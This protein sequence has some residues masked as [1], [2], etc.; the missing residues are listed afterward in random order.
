[1][2]EVLADP[3]AHEVAK[4]AACPN[5]RHIGALP[6]LSLPAAP[7]MV[8]SAF[9]D[10][11]DAL[12]VP[13]GD[14]DLAAC[15]SCGFLFSTSFDQAL[16][17]AGAKYE[18]SQAA[19]PHFGAFARALATDWVQRYGLEGKPIAE[20]GCG[21]GEFLIEMIRAGAGSAVGIDPLFGP[22]FI[23]A[24]FQDRI[25]ADPRDFG[26]DHIHGDAQALVC[27]HAIEH[28]GDVAGFLALVADWAA[29]HPGAP[30]L[31]EAPGT[32]RILAEGA[33]WDVF[34]EHCNYFTAD[35]LADSFARAGLNTTRCE[36]VYDGQYLIIE[37]VGTAPAILDSDPNKVAAAVR[38]AS[39]FSAKVSR[40][41]LLCRSRLAEMA[42]DGAPVVLW[43]GAS[44]T[45]ALMTLL[46]PD[47]PIAFAVDL[48]TRRHGN[49]L[50][51]FALEV[52]APEAL[53][54][55][56]PGHVVLMNEVYMK[57]VRQ[58]LDRLGLLDTQLHSINSLFA[59]D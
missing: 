5:C 16:A 41:V 32:E 34:Y 14:I 38:E 4:D 9:P 30:I 37:A 29:A 6:V 20:I 7:V 1:M 3:R 33:F 52:R 54:A 53:V 22:E 58:H 31:F 35:T 43:Q 25:T 24:E 26:G 36:L 27:R 49:F 2:V 48:N 51:P 15:T 19:S 23:P 57:E 45:V 28:I 18:S 59:E 47:T 13:S 50:P 21:Q 17:M 42:V 10:P 8:C 11:K 56:Q 12:D 55:A 44:K 39:A 46:G 40:A